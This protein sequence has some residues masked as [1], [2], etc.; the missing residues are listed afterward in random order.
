M[1]LVRS[2]QWPLAK[3]LGFD[4]LDLRRLKPLVHQALQQRRE[5]IAQVV[6]TLDAE[7]EYLSE[8]LL[9]SGPREPAQM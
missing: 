5:P 7:I 9:A 8:Q 3:T 4:P 1:V 6:M 2:R